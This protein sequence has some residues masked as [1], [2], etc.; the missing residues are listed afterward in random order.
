MPLTKDTKTEASE[1]I[2]YAKEEIDQSQRTLEEITLMIQQSQAELTRL[3]QRNA[4]ITGNLQQIIA[5]IESVPRSD[6]K[7][8]YA[9]A[10]D[11]Q[12]R[13]LV[14]RGQLDKLQSDQ[15][16]LQKYLKTLD[17]FQQIIGD[18]NLVGK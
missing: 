4:S 6:I 8:A 14:M 1:F 11:A 10:M 3:T 7:S 18:E 13:L 15:N 17:K 2:K 9:T 12:Q 5:Q 16:Y